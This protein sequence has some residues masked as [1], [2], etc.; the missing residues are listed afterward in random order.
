MSLSPS[1]KMHFLHGLALFNA[2]G[3]HNASKYSNTLA[4]KVAV[5]TKMKFLSKDHIV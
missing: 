3:T 1:W 5:N 2:I 4:H